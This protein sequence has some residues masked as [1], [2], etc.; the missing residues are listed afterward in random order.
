[1]QGQPVSSVYILIHTL[2]HTC[3]CIFSFFS[4]CLQFD[5]KAENVNKPL[6]KINYC[7]SNFECV[8]AI[9]DNENFLPLPWKGI[10]WLYI[11]D[12]SYNNALKEGLFAHFLSPSR[13]LLDKFLKIK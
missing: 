2:R 4:F 12:A 13:S 11:L 7:S 9:V 10:F 3:T 6:V 5:Y 8:L 1:M